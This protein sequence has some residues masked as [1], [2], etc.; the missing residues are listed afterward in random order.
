MCSTSQREHVLLQILRFSSYQPFEKKVLCSLSLSLTLATENT[1]LSHSPSILFN[2]FFWLLRMTLHYFRVLFL[3]RWVLSFCSWFVWQR[4][5][6]LTTSLHIE[7]SKLERREKLY[8]MNQIRL[9]EA[10][11]T[12]CLDDWKVL[13]LS[14]LVSPLTTVQPDIHLANTRQWQVA[15]TLS[16]AKKPMQQ[17]LEALSYSQ[18]L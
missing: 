9:E 11:E 13:F 18:L 4:R 7:T 3:S 6:N 17:E 12:L 1:L 5:L 15:I 10:E 8:W 14:A 16:S 2:F